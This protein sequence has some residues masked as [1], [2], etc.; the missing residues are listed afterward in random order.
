[1]VVSTHLK[2]M[3]LKLDHFPRDRGEHVRKKY[4]KPPP[5][6]VMNPKIV[7]N[8]GNAQ[9]NQQISKCLPLEKVKALPKKVHKVL[10]AHP[11]RIVDHH[12][13]IIC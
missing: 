9:Q 10:H 6:K 5:R 13:S 11:G 4:L 1:M 8:S 3:L 2:N 12:Q 7:A